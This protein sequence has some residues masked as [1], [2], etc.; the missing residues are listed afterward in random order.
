MK[1][2]KS[3][4]RKIEERRARAKLAEIDRKGR[5]AERADELA[6]NAHRFELAKQSHDFTRERHE[7]ARK[8]RRI[9]RDAARDRR[10]ARRDEITASIGAV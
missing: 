9:R 3:I 7:Q 2:G 6:E 4:H 5:P 10:R 8:D 1:I